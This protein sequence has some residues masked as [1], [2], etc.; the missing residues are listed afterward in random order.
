M[1]TRAIT[2]DERRHLDSAWN[3]YLT[4]AENAR[5]VTSITSVQSAIDEVV[6]AWDVYNE[7]RSQQGIISTLAG[8]RKRICTEQ[9]S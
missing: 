4:R 3:D 7:W 1:K 2:T 9:P 8:Y 5:S 6:D